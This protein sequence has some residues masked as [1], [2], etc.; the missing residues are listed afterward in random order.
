MDSLTYVTMLYSRFCIIVVVHSLT[1]HIQ[2]LQL[3]PSTQLGQYWAWIVSE[4][5]MLKVPITVPRAFYL[6][7]KAPLHEE[8]PGRRVNKIL[9]HSQPCFSLIEVIIDY[10][11]FQ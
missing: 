4:G 9:P 2:V 8:F 7:T 5:I 6:N 1:L 11:L 10:L 3:V